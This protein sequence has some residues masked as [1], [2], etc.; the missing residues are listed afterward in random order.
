LTD[1]SEP[2]VALQADAE[3][4]AHVMSSVA[5]AVR[6]PK[7]AELV[8]G[9]LRRQIVRGELKEGDALPAETALMEQF[10]VS[11]PTLREAFRVLESE[12]LITVR[13]GSHGG[14][15]VHVPND[16]VAA[17]Y[18]G[19]VLQFRGATLADVL[20]AR[21]VIEPPAAGLLAQRRTAA[22]LKR[23]QAAADAE[24]AAIDDPHQ[25][26]RLRQEF[27]LLVVEL[28][29][30]ETIRVLVGMLRHIVDTATFSKVA[31]DAGSPSERAAQH[32]GHRSHRRLI[33]YIDAKDSTGAEQLWRKHIVETTRYLTDSPTA[34]TVLELLS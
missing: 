15:R 2:T 22:D 34:S 14:A 17:R 28:A 6:V 8:A 5:R 20:E 9:H 16:D 33:D 11:R 4:R 26:I 31:R 13:R 21:A 19:L 7:T 18:A 32:T 30:N 1:E 3:D 29:G 10:A 27:H 23:L 25:S 24:D 12:A